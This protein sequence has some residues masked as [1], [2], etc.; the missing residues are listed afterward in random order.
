MGSQE[1]DTTERLYK[2]LQRGTEAEHMGEGLCPSPKAARDSAELHMDTP[3]PHL[4]MQV[5]SCSV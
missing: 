3:F 1:S 4:I 5:H 2:V